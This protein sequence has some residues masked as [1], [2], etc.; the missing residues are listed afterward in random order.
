MES[1]TTATEKPKRMSWRRWLIVQK[2]SLQRGYMWCQAVMLGVIFATSLNQWQIIRDVLH[3]PF[4]ALIVGSLTVLYLIGWCDRH[5]RLLHE[6][7]IYATE[8]NPTMMSGLRGELKSEKQSS[9]TE[10]RSEGAAA[11]RMVEAKE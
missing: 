9:R 2:Y 3:I 7:N 11:P 10:V 5:F 8:T 6:E 1:K 4:W